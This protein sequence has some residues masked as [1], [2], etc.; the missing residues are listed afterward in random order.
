MTY[1][2]VI[3]QNKFK[4]F[5]HQVYSFYIRRF[6][7]I[8]PLYYILLTIAFSF[9]D[10][11]F[12]A[13]NEIRTIV[14]PNWA[15]MASR[16]KDLI[17][18]TIGPLNVL[19][20]YTFTFGFLPKYVSSTFIPDWSIGLEMQFYLIFPFLILVGSRYGYFLIVLASIFIAF[21]THKLFG[22]YL[23][24]GPWGNFTQPSLILFKISIFVSGICF[25][26]SYLNRNSR[27]TILW[28]IL[29]AVS[30]YTTVLQVKLIVFASI[31]LLFLD[32]ER[33]I[34]LHRMGSGRFAKFF[35]D[36]SYSVYL[37]HP[38]I[39]FPVIAFFFRYE[40]FINFHPWSRLF[41][42]LLAT[43]IP[44]YGIAFLLFRTIELPGIMLGR[45]VASSFLTFVKR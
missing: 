40:W 2:W 14:V 41:I 8:A 11:F 25:A 38:L 22:L 5:K 17:D 4:H 27:K 35:G 24:V 39:V 32:P 21:M 44:V 29:G 19:S 30:L 18:T 33:K 42:A 36:I 31:A 9:Q 37:L 20:H 13:K 1:H 43:T 16:L 45:R 6:F 7:R 12:A 34:F 26:N 28:I 15:E 23:S 10:Y 3:R